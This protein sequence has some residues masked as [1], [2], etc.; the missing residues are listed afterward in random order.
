M[1]H[2]G[3]ANC[4]NRAATCFFTERQIAQTELLC[5]SS[6]SNRGALCF[7]TERPTAMYFIAE[8][9][10]HFVFY[11]REAICDNRAATCFIKECQVAICDNRG[12]TCFLFT[13]Q[14]HV[15]P[16][17]RFDIIKL[18]RYNSIP[19]LPCDSSVANR[20]N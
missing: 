4:D 8:Q 15:L 1:F 17:V 5:V 19:S 3:T 18:K 2:H 9:Q 13:N 7:I 20:H 6:L 12:A 16:Y 10:R 14:T 11:H